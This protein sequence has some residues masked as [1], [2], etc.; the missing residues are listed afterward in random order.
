M[1][2]LNLFFL[3]LLSLCTSACSEPISLLARMNCTTLYLF[4]PCDDWLLRWVGYCSNPTQIPHTVFSSQTIVLT[5]PAVL[6]QSESPDVSQYAPD[7]RLFHRLEAPTDK[8]IDQLITDALGGIDGKT[9]KKIL[10]VFMRVKTFHM[11]IVSMGISGRFPVK[12]ATC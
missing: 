12:Q 6:S 9:E 3:N 4:Y 8:T 11:R 7:P 1:N 10:L 2:T 5:S